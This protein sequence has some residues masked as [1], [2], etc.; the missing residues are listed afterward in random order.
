MQ[1]DYIPRREAE[2]VIW[3]LNIE[4]KID[5]FLAPLGIT[6]AEATAIKTRCSSIRTSISAN[7]AARTAAKQ[8][9]ESKDAV[10][11]TE[12]AVLRNAIQ[13]WKLKSTFTEAVA[14]ALGLNAPQSRMNMDDYKTQLTT[15]TFPGKIEINFTKKG[16]DGVNIYVRHKG[17]ST[18]MKIAYDSH[19]PYEDNRP[20]AISGT[21][22]T[23]EYMA[24][25]VIDDEEIGQQSDIVE[26][27]FGG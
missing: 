23:R 2:K 21:A 19:S 16:V 22:E 27:V 26:V 3:L 6:A 20:L 5:T 4:G 10:I 25:G 18:F 11:K 1:T 8:A 24:M 9:K 17:Q 13:T 14:E 12:E 15:Q 7:E